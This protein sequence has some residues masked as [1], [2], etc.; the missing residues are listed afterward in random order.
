MILQRTS[1]GPDWGCK[2]ERE[3][4]VYLLPLPLPLPLPLLLASAA[5]AGF[6]GFEHCQVAV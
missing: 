6:E 4:I 1:G 2:T 5:A 3:A